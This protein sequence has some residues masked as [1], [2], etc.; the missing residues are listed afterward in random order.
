M[1][2]HTTHLIVLWIAH[3]PLR[4]HFVAGVIPVID[5]A[6]LVHV[7]SVLYRSRRATFSMLCPFLAYLCSSVVYFRVICTLT[8]TVS[9]CC[10]TLSCVCCS[11]VLSVASLSLTAVLMFVDVMLFACLCCVMLLCCLSFGLC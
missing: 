8:P 2:C 10:C 7:G 6:L 11:S 4:C 3:I 1:L 5:S 9:Q